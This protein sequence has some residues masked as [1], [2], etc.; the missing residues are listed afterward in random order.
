MTL[1]QVVVV[2]YFLWKDHFST[3]IIIDQG[4]I[5]GA[6]QTGVDQYVNNEINRDL[7]GGG[8][9]NNGA[10]TNGGGIF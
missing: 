4:L 8:L 10:Q 3:Y 2:S 7:F 6:A 1:F 9:G 5:G